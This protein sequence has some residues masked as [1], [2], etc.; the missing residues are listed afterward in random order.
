MISN[1]SFNSSPWMRGLNHGLRDLM[2]PI[3]TLSAKRIWRDYGPTLKITRLVDAFGVFGRNR[4]SLSQKSEACITAT[5]DR[6]LIRSVSCSPM[7]R[8]GCS[9][10]SEDREIRG[11]AISTVRPKIAFALDRSPDLLLAS[12]QYQFTQLFKF[13]L[14]WN[15]W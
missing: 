14:R 13:R 11:L 1:P 15:F 8:R 4:L 2:K 6:C 10:W 9:A 3:Q 5:M 12:I 7:L